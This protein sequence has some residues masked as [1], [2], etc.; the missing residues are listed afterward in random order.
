[1]GKRSKNKL[2]SELKGKSIEERVRR[3][4]QVQQ[5]VRYA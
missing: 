2:S 5:E 1:M 4:A 3:F